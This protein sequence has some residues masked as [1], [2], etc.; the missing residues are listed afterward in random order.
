MTNLFILLELTKGEKYLIMVIAI[1]ILLGVGVLLSWIYR[2][3]TKEQSL[4]IE[5]DFCGVQDKRNPL[6]SNSNDPNGFNTT[7][8]FFVG[9]DGEI[10]STHDYFAEVMS[11]GINYIVELD[12]SI[13]DI[14]KQAYNE[15]SRRI[16]LEC[17]K[18]MWS[19]RLIA[20]KVLYV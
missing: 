15:G 18:I 17:K 1:I 6:I 2:Y 9:K 13:F 20:T 5:G 16:T 14:L 3:F 4:E 11:G 10:L 8:T 19:G 7:P 12:K